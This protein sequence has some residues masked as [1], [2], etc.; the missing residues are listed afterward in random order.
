M[1]AIDADDSEKWKNQLTTKKIYKHG[2]CW[3]KVK[4]SSGK[5]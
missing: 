3:K 1:Y 4:M 5:R 2:D